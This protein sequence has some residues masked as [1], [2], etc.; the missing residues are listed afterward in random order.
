MID[1]LKEQ[2]DMGVVFVTHDMGVVAEIADKVMV[3]YH[4]E[5]VETGDVHAIFNNP[6]HDYTR[7]LLAAVPNVD[8]ENKNW[9]QEGISYD[10]ITTTS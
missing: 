9:L 4:G 5:V 7:S 3:M 2:M 8:D 10:S 6:Q 1:E